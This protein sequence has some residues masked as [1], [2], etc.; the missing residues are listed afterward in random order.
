MIRNCWSSLSLRWPEIASKQAN[1][2][3]LHVSV[4]WAFLSH[5]QRQLNWCFLTLLHS[6]RIIYAFHWSIPQVENLFRNLL[7]RNLVKFGIFVQFLQNCGRQWFPGQV[8]FDN[9]KNVR[10]LSTADHANLGQICRN[11]EA[12]I[13]KPAWCHQPVLFSTIKEA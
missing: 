7:C 2:T 11:S 8:C 10:F 12:K 9:Q 3:T 4:V 13:W 6:L 5:K 1:V